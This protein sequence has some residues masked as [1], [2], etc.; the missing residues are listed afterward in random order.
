VRLLLIYAAQLSIV[1]HRAANFIFRASNT[2]T[3]RALVYNVSN[4]PN[5]LNIYHELAP[6]HQSYIVANLFLA[7]HVYLHTSANAYGMG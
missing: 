6:S 5:V 2:N 4:P 1:F 3:F 7:L